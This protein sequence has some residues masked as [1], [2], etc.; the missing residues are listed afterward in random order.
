MVSTNED[1]L[2]EIPAGE[3][4]FREGE[5]GTEMYI[6]HRGRVE[7]L[8]RVADEENDEALLAVFEQGDFFGE[9]SLLDDQPR[10]ASVK[11]LEDTVLVCID[12]A[13]FIQMLRETPEIA[14]RMMRKLSRR[15][16]HTDR[17]LQ[18]ALDGQGEASGEVEA[19]AEVAA[20][21]ED[22][23]AHGAVALRYKLVDANSSTTF[24]IGTQEET[25]IGRADPVTG[26]RPSVDL[27]AIDTQRSCSR[28]HARIF[29][30]EG[31]LFLVEEIGS[32][33]GTFV[34]GQRLDTG[35]PVEIKQGDI[36]RFG[37]LKL[38]LQSA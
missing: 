27:T 30:R 15:L 35:A 10:S 11:A 29:Q 26:I 25:L 8:K 20:P 23:A 34:N 21:E 13:T 19:A 7:I 31:R 22:G 38:E 24:E 6:V 36:L 18:E 5:L 14:V 37:V 3:Y 2:V 33:N 12:G 1:H 32:M 16:R 9:L 28:R 4:V 17:L